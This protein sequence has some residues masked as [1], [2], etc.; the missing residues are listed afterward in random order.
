MAS[1][2]TFQHRVEVTGGMLICVDP[3]CRCGHEYPAMLV[4]DGQAGPITL[5]D[6]NK[7]VTAH[8]ARHHTDVTCTDVS[9]RWC[10]IH[11]TCRCPNPDSALAA[12]YDLSH[13][14]CPLHAPDSDHGVP[15]APTKG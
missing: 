7:A 1:Y 6:I 11:G 2:A 5:H 10:P 4:L 13:P 3:G 15:D 9:A 14:S 12:G 8:R